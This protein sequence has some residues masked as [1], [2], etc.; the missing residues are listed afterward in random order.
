MIIGV[1][2][3]LVSEQRHILD[4]L[5]VRKADAGISF[6]WLCS[7]SMLESPHIKAE[8][9]PFPFLHVVSCTVTYTEWRM[10]GTLIRCRLGLGLCP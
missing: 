6:Y 1:Y 2:V 10:R 8:P 7:Q 3:L 4:A 9:Q 5:C